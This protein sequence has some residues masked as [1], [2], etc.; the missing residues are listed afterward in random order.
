MADVPSKNPLKPYA[1]ATALGLGA[2]NAPPVFVTG[3]EVAPQAQLVCDTVRTGFLQGDRVCAFKTAAPAAPAQLLE[4]VCDE[5]GG[6]VERPAA[7]A[8]EPVPDAGI[9]SDADGGVR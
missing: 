1:I 7:L 8:A 2:A 9:T 3:E 4:I 5:D 6:C